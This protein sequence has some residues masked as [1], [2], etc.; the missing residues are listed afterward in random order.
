MRPLCFVNAALAD[1][2]TSLRV[3]GERIA[4]V[5]VPP[6]RGDRIVDLE[7]D[8]LL[9]GLINAHDHLQFS[10][11]PRMRCREG[12]RNA[13]EWIADV[14]ARR[15]HDPALFAAQRLGLPARLFAG[16]V[17]NL[18]AGTTTVAHHDPFHDSL[19]AR[20]FPVRVLREYRWSHSPAL[21]PARELAATHHATPP[22]RP[23]IVHAGEGVDAAAAAEFTQLEALGCVDARTLLVHALGFDT[24]QL[25]RL[26]A[27]GAGVIWCPSSNLYLFGRTLDPVPLLAA[28]RLALGSDSR[29][30][31]GRDLLEELEVARA[32][33][34]GC[35][36]QLEDLV[37]A[38][39]ARLLRLVDRGSLRAGALADLVILPAGRGLAGLRRHEL[40]MAMVGGELRYGDPHYA[41]Q[42]GVESQCVP[43]RV[44]GRRK[45][46]A[47]AIAARLASADWCEPG[48]ELADRRGRAA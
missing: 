46:L 36:R 8:R 41:A 10:N 6:L 47:R 44:D 17:K 12:Y 39:N 43:A 38:G 22:Q 1:G 20:A 30:S 48:L 40:R 25:D 31:G 15:S 34:P 14:A 7:G 33:A 35:A 18:L 29:I 3:A 27:A 37:T 16:G 9:P 26:A 19:G 11:F 21:T 42:L 2:S 23:W 45:V 5:G 24:A 4:G 13:S 28:G 32:A